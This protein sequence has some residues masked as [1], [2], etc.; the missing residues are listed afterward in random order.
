MRNIKFLLKLFKFKDS[1][2]SGS[3]LLGLIGEFYSYP[4]SLK[5]RN[6][7]LNKNIITFKGVS[8]KDKRIKLYTFRD[9]P[10][11]ELAKK[12]SDENK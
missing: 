8:K 5:I 7:L 11:D 10:L 12:L 9:L 4:K 2:L 6:K 3:E 1:T